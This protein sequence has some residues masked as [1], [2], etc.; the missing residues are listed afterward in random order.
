MAE[1]SGASL[2]PTLTCS[3]LTQGSPEDTHLGSHPMTYVH[4]GDILCIW[5]LIKT[6]I[7]LQGILQL[8]IR[9]NMAKPEGKEE[10][11]HTY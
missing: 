5:A 9:G 4:D 11:K 8:N 3:S 2:Y 1:P 7:S 10:R 6:Q